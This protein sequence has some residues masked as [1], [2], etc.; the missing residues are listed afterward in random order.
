MQNTFQYCISYERTFKP[1][2]SDFGIH[3]EKR[4]PMSEPQIKRIK[5]IPQML[6]LR[7]QRTL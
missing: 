2:D 3:P 7:K 6:F 4:I 1:E 5:R